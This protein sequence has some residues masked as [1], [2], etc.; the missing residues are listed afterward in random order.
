MECSGV[1]VYPPSGPG[2]RGFTLHCQGAALREDKKGRPLCAH[3]FALGRRD[4][5]E[6]NPHE[7]NDRDECMKCGKIR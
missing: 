1:R 6:P 7:W 5:C 4:F 2:R 3:H